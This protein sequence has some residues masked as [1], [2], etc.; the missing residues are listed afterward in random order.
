[1]QMCEA[2]QKCL[3]VPA[4]SL[5]VEGGSPYLRGLYPSMDR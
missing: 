1:M 4:E 2:R 3:Q 5:A